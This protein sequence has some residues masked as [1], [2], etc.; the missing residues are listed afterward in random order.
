MQSDD[1]CQLFHQ[2]HLQRTA[3]TTILQAYKT[4]ILHVHHSILLQE[5]RIN[6]H[7]AYIVYYYR[8]LDALL[9][10]QYVIYKGSL[11]TA[12]ITSQ[13]QHR[14]FV[15]HNFIVFFTAFDSL[16]KR[17]SAVITYIYLVSP[18]TYGNL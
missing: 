9:V 13:Q 14:Y 18:F 10:G 1:V 17:S 5:A 15:F 2:I 16:C 11:T 3:D 4:L 12:K 8:K 7:F 6:I